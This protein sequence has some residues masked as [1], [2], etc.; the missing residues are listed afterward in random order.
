MKSIHQRIQNMKMATGEE[1]RRRW[2]EDRGRAIGLPLGCVVEIVWLRIEKT[3]AE[4]HD[5]GNKGGHGR[6]WVVVERQGENES[7][8]S[9]WPRLGAGAT[10]CNCGMAWMRDRACMRVARGLGQ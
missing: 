7:T 2:L 10:M 1:S 3:H 4:T 5:E 9:V 8:S 6:A